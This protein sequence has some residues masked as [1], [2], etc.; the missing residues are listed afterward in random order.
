METMPKRCSFVALPSEEEEGIETQARMRSSGLILSVCGGG[1]EGIS[2]AG[3]VK[4]SIE[5]VYFDIPLHSARVGC[6][7]VECIDAALFERME[8]WGVSL[9][10]LI[11]GKSVFPARELKLEKMIGKMDLIRDGP[12]IVPPWRRESIRND[13]ESARGV[14]YL[15]TRVCVCRTESKRF[16]ELP[17]LLP[18]QAPVNSGE[19]GALD[20]VHI[21][22]ILKRVRGIKFL[23]VRN[24]GRNDR[25]CGGV[26]TRHWLKFLLQLDVRLAA[27]LYGW[28]MASKKNQPVLILSHEW[29]PFVGGFRGRGEGRGFGQRPT[30][31]MDSR[32]TERPRMSRM[33]P[34][35]YEQTWCIRGNANMTSGGGQADQTVEIIKGIQMNLIRLWKGCVNTRHLKV[36][37]TAQR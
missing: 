23:L 16:S 28:A 37:D 33:E 5:K 1:P 12:S 10:I 22:L 13:I 11:F 18:F 15:S 32:R 19:S 21:I 24:D 7:S 36:Y 6:V 8:G 14:P 3:H 9:L 17:T 31:V 4:I 25:R 2:I 35:A 29:K 26:L 20:D 34:R 27:G 30:G